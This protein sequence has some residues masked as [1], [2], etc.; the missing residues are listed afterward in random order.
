[1]RF[2]YSEPSCCHMYQFLFCMQQQLQLQLSLRVRFYRQEVLLA[3]PNIEWQALSPHQFV[4]ANN[5][6]LMNMLIG[7]KVE[8]NLIL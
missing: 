1:M 3:L 5:S 8:K 2:H 6:G 7:E 4:I